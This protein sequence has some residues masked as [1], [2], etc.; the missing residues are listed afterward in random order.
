[1]NPGKETIV[2]VKPVEITT[3][4]PRTIGRNAV[5][6]SHGAG[7]TSGA[8]IL[9]TASGAAGWG[10][11]CGTPGNPE[12]LVGRRLDELFDPAV[13]VVE[14]AV[15]W[16]DFALHDLAGVL[17][18]QPVHT[19]LGGQGE[20]TIPVYDATIYFDDLDPPDNPGGVD[21][22]LEHVQDGWNAGYRGFKLKIGG[23]FTWMPEAEGL[24][25]DVAV[26]RAVREAFPSA[27]LL[28]DGNNGFTVDGVLRY[29][30]RVADVGLFWLEEP[31]HEHRAGLERLRAWRDEN[32]LQMLIADG[33]HQPNVD[34]VVAYAR[35]GLIDVLLMDIVDFGLTPWRQ[36]SPAL[37]ASGIHSSP[38]AWGLPLKTL[39]A[40]Q[41]GAGLPGV[42]IVEGVR[43][44]TLGV[45][46]SGYFMVDGAISVPDTPG[47]GL[48]LPAH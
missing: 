22:I 16:A 6:A 40:A 23:G 9:H 10:M 33:E 4:Y 1:M 11:V 42:I 26:T 28:V 46:T 35:E 13:G 17:A 5:L 32:D 48:P 25:R 7:P 2:S 39:Y 21:I 29:L 8:M 37:V 31:F 41:T 12:Q 45:D 30:D 27:R 15:L 24:E 19:M 44:E 36:L 3:R 34:E 18:G 14:D 47:F 38:H 43:G 20:R